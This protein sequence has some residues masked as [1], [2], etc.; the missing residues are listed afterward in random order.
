MDAS[1]YSLKILFQ[2]LDKTKSAILKSEIE[3]HEAINKI[4]EMKYHTCIELGRNKLILVMDY[5]DSVDLFEF[6]QF[7]YK[8]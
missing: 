5:F 4:N 1:K 7:L 2:S 3:T 8:M 6:K